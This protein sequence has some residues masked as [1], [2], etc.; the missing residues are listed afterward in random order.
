VAGHEALHHV[1]R[2]FVLSRL[3]H[4]AEALLAAVDLLP[5]G[6]VHIGRRHLTPIYNQPYSG[7]YFVLSFPERDPVYS[8]SLWDRTLDTRALAPGKTA[9]WHAAGPQGQRLLVW[10]GGFRKRGLALTVAVAEDVSPLEQQLRGYEW[11]LAGIAGGGV[12]LILL[13]QWGVIVHTFRKLQPVY[14]DIERLERGEA[15]ALSTDLPDEVLPLVHK[16]NRLLE[17]YRQRLERSRRA[18]GNLAH[19]LKGPLSLAG[20]QAEQTEPALRERLG[21]Q[22]ERIRQLMERELKRARFAGSGG[23]GQDFRPGEELPVL[24]RLLEQM[25]PDKGLNVECRIDDG[26]ALHA[27]REDI[28]ELI[29][30]LLDNAC[31]WAASR[32]LCRVA[33][34]GDGSWT[35][36]VEDDGPGCSD[37]VPS[38][39]SGRGVR[40]DE[41]IGGYGLGLSIVED[42]VAL[43]QGRIDFGRS[44]ELGGFKARVILPMQ[45][46][47]RG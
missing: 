1:A 21:E 9:Q 11:V 20:Q 45:S 44:A 24:S 41:S 25:Y 15:V 3:H 28:L 34:D 16:L 4:D 29:G 18:A 32:V 31:K 17:Q 14:D 2:A 23:P 47:G 10:A 5:G 35:L 12:V 38:H 39:I 46:P 43:Y 30:N 40:L 8:G 22:L 27:D 42:I 26:R 7:H 33:Q 13:V 37:E 19:A 6:Q 36:T